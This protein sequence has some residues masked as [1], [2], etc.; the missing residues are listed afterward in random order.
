MDEYA[1]TVIVPVYQVED[2][3]EECVQSIVRSS[4]FEKCEV[5][6]VNDGSRDGSGEIAL[7]Y[8]ARYRNCHL[9]EKK[10]GG[11]GSAR[12]L[13]M[14]KAQ[15]RYLYFVDGD[16]FISSDRLEK[17]YRCAE[18]WDCDMVLASYQEY[19]GRDSDTVCNRDYLVASEAVSGRAMIGLRMDYSDWMNQSFT[20]LIRRELIQAGSIYFPEENILYEDII[21]MNRCLMMAEKVFYIPDYGY[22]YRKREGSAVSHLGGVSRKDLTDSMK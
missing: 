21:W 8:A 19:R 5:L 6:L 16:D 18:T 10:N 14:R 12:N 20:A 22:Y 1:I 2:Y 4:V 17:L 13:G 11:A 15:G 3:I 9:L 7:K